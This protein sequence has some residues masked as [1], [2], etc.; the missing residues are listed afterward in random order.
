MASTPIEADVLVVGAGASGVP[1]A[2]GAAG[3][4]AKVVLLAR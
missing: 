3:A 4:G 2:I 1:A